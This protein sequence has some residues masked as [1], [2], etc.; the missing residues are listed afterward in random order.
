MEIKKLNFEK[1]KI[2][3]KETY[4]DEAG[5]TRERIKK[6]MLPTGNVVANDHSSLPG[7]DCRAK[8]T[9]VPYSADSLRHN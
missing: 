5:K 3:I 6:V 2:E 8:R 4:I 7:A 1:K 9:S